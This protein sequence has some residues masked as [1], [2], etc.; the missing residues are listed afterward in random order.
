MSDSL[1]SLREETLARLEKSGSEAEIEQIRV[2]ALG[3]K[4]KLT[5][6]LRG[7]KDLPLDQRRRAG[8]QLNILRQLLENRL[9]DRLQLVKVRQKAKAL[10]EEFIDVTL[11]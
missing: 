11:P 8:E 10:R 2:E 4:G 9:Q 3:R 6:L 7:L 5:L 1:D